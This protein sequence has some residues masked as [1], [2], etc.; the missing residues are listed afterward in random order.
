MRLA[1]PAMCPLVSPAESLAVGCVGALVTMGVCRLLILCRVDD[2]VGATAVHGAAGC[3]SLIAVGLFAAVDP[4]E[5]KLLEINGQLN[6][7]LL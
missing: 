2:P 5:E 3:W 1:V 4:T 6:L 7:R